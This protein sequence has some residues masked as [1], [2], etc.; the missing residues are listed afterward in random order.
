M[1]SQKPR[2]HFSLFRLTALEPKF[3][4]CHHYRLLS[5]HPSLLPTPSWSERKS[6]GSLEEGTGVTVQ[7][8]AGKDRKLWGMWV[9]TIHPFLPSPCQPLRPPLTR[10]EL[11]FHPTPT[12]HSHGSQGPGAIFSVPHPLIGSSGSSSLQA[13]LKPFYYSEEP[14][15]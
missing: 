15:D 11:Q 14:L 8:G 5:A 10:K 13:Q 12:A 1:G 9:G 7:A 3:R 2:G 4:P 6:R